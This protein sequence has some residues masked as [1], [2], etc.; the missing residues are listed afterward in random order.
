MAVCLHTRC[1]KFE[2]DC[3]SVRQCRFLVR[4]TE[5]NVI[6]FRHPPTSKCAAMKVVVAHRIRVI[7]SCREG[8]PT[9]S[10]TKS[11]RNSIKCGWWLLASIVRSSVRTLL[12][13]LEFTPALPASLEIVLSLNLKLLECRGSFN[14]RRL[15]V[16]YPQSRSRRA[17]ALKYEPG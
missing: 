16:S 7:N 15:Q 10:R 13:L 14:D 5:Y 6:I 12:E 17:L 1:P 4:V 11:S 8:Y 3:T 9:F 2:C